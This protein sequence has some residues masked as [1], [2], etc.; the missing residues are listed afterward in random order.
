MHIQCTRCMEKQIIMLQFREW[1]AQA[2]EDGNELQTTAF[3][4]F[5]KQII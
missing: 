4:H 5:L 3:F 2:Y 1:D